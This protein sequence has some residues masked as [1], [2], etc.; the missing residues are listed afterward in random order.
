MRQEELGT[1][2]EVLA[3]HVLGNADDGDPARGSPLV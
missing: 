3:A 2:G 1:G